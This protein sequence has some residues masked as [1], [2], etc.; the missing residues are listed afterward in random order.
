MNFAQRF[1]AGLK[2][3]SLVFSSG[4]RWAWST[5]LGRTKFDYAG[6]VGNGRGNAALMAVI[7]WFCRTFPEAPIR[8]STIN[9]Q[10]ETTEQPNHPLKKLLDSPNPFYSG[11]LLWWATM[12]DWQ[13]G[14]AYWLKVPSAADR[15]RPEQ[16]WW[17]PASMIEPRWPDDGSEFISHY[18][19][20]PNAQAIRLERSEVVHF[21]YGLDPHNM[22]K[23]LSP[24]GALTREL[25]TDDEAANYT[26]SMLRNVGVPPVIV[27]PKL[28][29]NGIGP[30]MDQAAAD[31]VKSRFT[32]L[33]TGDNRGQTIVMRGATE[34]TTLGFNPQQMNVRD[35]RKIPEERVTAVYGI[36]AVV[37]GLG[38]GL[39][40]STFANFAEAREA[41][42]ESNLIPCQRLIAAELRTQLLPHFGNVETLKIDFD[43]SKVRVL[44][45][46]QNALHARSLADLNGGLATLNEAREAVGL[47]PLPGKAGDVLYIP[48]TV[49]PTDPDELLAQPE[50]LEVTELPPGAP[51]QT[52]LP[53]AGAPKMLPLRRRK[54]IAVGAAYGQVSK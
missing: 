22:R 36:P 46:D 49:T 52:A 20:T 37:V 43:L 34:I 28:D 12:A 26:A 21:R 31:E 41:A 35:L 29:A 3:F 48:G 10:G 4:S 11:E 6:E 2:A 15:N 1:G 38:A 23:G 53:P 32:E 13:F 54:S 44:Q 5:M 7:Y 25:F 30:K 24:L 18:E 42:Y 19:Y 33:S 50:P 51:G 45:D 9:R 8:V 39:D 40:R 17:I 47:E 27:S 16:L 14:N